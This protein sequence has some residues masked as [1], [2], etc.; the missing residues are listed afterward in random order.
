MELQNR[1]VDALNNYIAVSTVLT[2]D[3]LEMSQNEKNNE[4]WKR[5]YIR[6]N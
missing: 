3:L 6:E 5:N 1:M 4:S 2:S